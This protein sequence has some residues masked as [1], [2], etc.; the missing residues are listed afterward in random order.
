MTALAWLANGVLVATA[1]TVAFAVLSNSGHGGSI[2]CWRCQD[3]P[4]QRAGGLCERCLR[5]FREVAARGRGG[6]E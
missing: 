3:R 6:E 2:W 5:E 1:L 4:A